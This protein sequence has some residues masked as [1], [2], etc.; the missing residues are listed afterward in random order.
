MSI[1]RLDPQRR[2]AAH[3]S[4][5]GIGA[6]LVLGGLAANA[7]VATAVAAQRGGTL[8]V[9]MPSE[10]PSINPAL[11]SNGNLGV[12]FEEL[13][14]DS[15]IRLGV[16]GQYLPDLATKWKYVGKSNKKFVLTLRKGVKVR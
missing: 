10:Q 6:V 13:A 1:N 9:A 2:W 7:N 14:Y 12:P 5:I 4:V 8:T 11:A 16:N 3:R 15:L